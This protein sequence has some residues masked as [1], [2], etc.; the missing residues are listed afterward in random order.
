M[1]QRRRP[2]PPEWEA[3]VSTYDMY[4][5]PVA[6]GTW[7]VPAAGAA[8]FSWEYDSWR[9]QLLDLYQRGKDKQWD[10]VKRI[11]WEQPVN[12]LRVM[13]T[14]EEL[15]PIYG[16]RQWEKLNQ[17]ERDEV[18]HH[19]SSWLFS[20]FLHGEQGAL[21]VAAR[22]VESVPDMDSKFYAATQVMDEARH[23]EL[24]SRFIKEKIGLFYPVNGDLA[25]LLADA[26]SDSR[27][28]LPYLGMQVLI[29]GLALAAFG[30]HRDL[31]GNPLVKQLLAYVMQDEARHVAF[32]RLALRDYYAGL[33]S[34]ERAEREE[35]VVEG[36]Y[37]M[38]DRFIARE[39]WERLDFDVEECVEFTDRSP[40]QVAFRQFL[41]S[42]IVPCVKDI[43][44]WGSK[45]QR[46]YVDLGVMDA[47][48]GDLEAL[49]R[50]D[51]ETAD[52]VEREHAAELAAR[53]QEVG[54]AIA[55]ASE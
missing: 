28:D 19:L 25:K 6:A 45:V 51:E 31:T 12:P 41:F 46:A 13:E 42:R 2:L 20:Q 4:T 53:K 30:V 7:D 17:S 23:V 39:V 16:S 37:L 49:M 29:E 48:S 26:L 36:C 38:R 35:F 21:T 15:T 11:D 10:A 8:R 44:L 14:G 52:R 34:A 9:Q 3:R 18:N 24:F 40:T 22:I 54:A 43:G 27:W 50:D 1:K 5:S 33:T 55:S 32:G 47:A